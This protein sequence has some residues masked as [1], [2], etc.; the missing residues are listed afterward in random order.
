MSLWSIVF[1]SL[2]DLA[3]DYIDS[4]TD[5]I[6]SFSKKIYVYALLTVISTLMFCFSLGALIVKIGEKLD[7][8]SGFYWLNSMTFYLAIT[9][10]SIGSIFY[11]A[12]RRNKLYTP[13]LEE[14]VE[15]ILKTQTRKKVNQEERK[16]NEQYKI[17]K[18]K[19]T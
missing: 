16:Q 14:R 4:A 18:E 17:S 8:P 12:N 9:T 15:T 6:I 5:R 19:S 13:S 2:K 7:D 3:D 1:D 10:V 11:I